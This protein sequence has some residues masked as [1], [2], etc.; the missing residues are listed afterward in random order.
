MATVLPATAEP[1]QTAEPSP[2]DQI[3]AILDQETEVVEEK[4]AKPSIEGE[5]AAPEESDGTPEDKPEEAKEEAEEVE[6]TA[7]EEFA[8]IPLEQLESIILEVKVKGEDGA[9]VLEKPTIKELR[10]GYMRQ[11]DYSRKTAEVARQREQAQ[12]FIRQGI[13]SER[14]SMLATL[15]QLRSVVVETAA[16][17]LKDVDWNAL[18]TNDPFEYIR[19]RNRAEQIDKVLKGIHGKQ[20]ELTTKRNEENAAALKRAAEESLKT[21]Q[22]D[23]PGWNEEL[24]QGLMQTA[25]KDYG[26][27][28]DEVQSWIDPKAFKVLHDAQ[29]FRK[30]GT[31]KPVAKPVLEK[32]VVKVPKFV[33]PGSTQNK[34]TKAQAQESE[35]MKRLQK[36]GKREDAAAVILSRLG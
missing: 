16:P 21:L 7:Q 17:E 36:S 15:D 31:Q 27:K 3:K 29:Q 19:L 9:D 5:D 4:P 33:K 30:L 34:V 11:K 8:E 12:E 6:E 13:E 28:P 18:S 2:V 24:Y 1:K 23:I 14:N 32:K 26:Y 20:Q 25:I 22:S 10:E 35:A